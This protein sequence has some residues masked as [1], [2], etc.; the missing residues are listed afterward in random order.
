MM[1]SGEFYAKFELCKKA[2]ADNWLTFHCDAIDS[3]KEEK[4]PNQNRKQWQKYSKH[5]IL[6][7]SEPA[8]MK[9]H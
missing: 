9:F 5:G 7:E 6:V 3:I 4:K 2:T 1:W 8:F